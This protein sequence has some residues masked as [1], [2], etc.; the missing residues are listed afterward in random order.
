MK[1]EEMEKE[2]IIV[3]AEELSAEIGVINITRKNLCERAGIPDGSFPHVMGENFSEFIKKINDDGGFHEVSKKRL[4]KDDRKNHILQVAIASAK[5]YGY[6]NV[7][8]NKLADHAKVSPA[9]VT[10]YFSTM[11]QLKRAIMRAA[12][13]LEIPEI[14]AQGLALGDKNARKAPGELKTKAAEILVTM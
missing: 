5:V 1:R 9:L 3:A 7:T 10:H 11:P 12:I 8:R 14:I 4:S 2:K 6:A 13:Q